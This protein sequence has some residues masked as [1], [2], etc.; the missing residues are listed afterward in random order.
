MTKSLRQ[1]S[2]N[3]PHQ[4]CST[5]PRSCLLSSGRSELRRGERGG[6]GG[7]FMKKKR[8]PFVIVLVSSFSRIATDMPILYPKQ[9]YYSSEHKEEP[10]PE[11]KP[12]QS[13]PSGKSLQ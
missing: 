9:E 5:G 2:T 7:R 8:Y 12:L 1:S 11:P 10:D 4:T 13:K 6:R 3:L